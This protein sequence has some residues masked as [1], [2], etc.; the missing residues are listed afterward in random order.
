MDDRRDRRG[1]CAP[2]GLA[3]FSF[4]LH[5]KEAHILEGLEG[6]A[7]DG[8]KGREAGVRRDGSGRR[9]HAPAPRGGA[10]GDVVKVIHVDTNGFARSAMREQ[11]PR[12]APEAELHGFGR[13]EP[14][15]MFAEAEGCDVLLTEVELG[16]ERLGGIRLAEAMRELNPRVGVV[17]VTVCGEDE[18]ARELA[19]LPVGGFLPKPWTQE[20]LAAAF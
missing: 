14:A 1:R 19:G 9:T 2:P 12:I 16:P 20:E 11:V 13:A 17:F 18:V 3:V 4:D 8:P 10:L 15:L 5:V 6:I 7:R